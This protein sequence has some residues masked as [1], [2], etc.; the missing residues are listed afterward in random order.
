M[1]EILHT[2]SCKSQME[3]THSIKV[4]RAHFKKTVQVYLL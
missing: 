1:N 2:L 4:L 3:I